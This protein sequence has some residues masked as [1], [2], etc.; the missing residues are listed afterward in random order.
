MGPSLALVPAAATLVALAGCQPRCADGSTV[1]ITF[2]HGVVQYSGTLVMAA[3][4]IPL[5]C[6]QESTVD[7]W[8]VTCGFQGIVVSTAGVDFNKVRQALLTLTAADGERLAT[9]L[10]VTLGAP[11]ELG[12]PAGTCQRTAE[13][14]LTNMD[15]PGLLLTLSPTASD[16]GA[17]VVG[18]SSSPFEFTLANRSGVAAGA[19]QLDVVGEFMVTSNDCPSPFVAGARCLVRVV[20][21]P[22]RAGP[23]NGILAA[24][25][26]PSGPVMSSLS[27]T[28]VAPDAATGE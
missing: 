25:V 21:R 9:D 5:Q 12:D 26:E 18:G 6:P 27:G 23:Q 28:G 11:M 15:H 3:R 2:R 14:T 4:R 13:V 1:H 7:G 16:F 22:T 8:Q 10:L 24:R 19:V 17:V 20:F